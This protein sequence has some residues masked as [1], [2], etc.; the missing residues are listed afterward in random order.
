MAL[1]AALEELLKTLPVDVQAQQ[2]AILE[3]HPALGEGWLRQ[4]DYSQK[5]NEI[6]DRKKV[7]DE[8]DE[9]YKRNRPIYDQLRTDYQSSQ[10]R[11]TALEAEVQAKATELAAARAAG[12][13]GGGDPQAVAKAVMDSLQGKIPTQSELSKM[14]EDMTK[15][16]A[17]AAREAFFKNDVPS[18]LAFQTAMNDVQWRYRDEF[19][20]S[21]DRIEFAKFMKDNALADP[22]DAYDKYTAKAREERKLAEARA[23]GKAEGRKE[24]TAE[25]VPGSTGPQSPGHLQLRISEKKAGDPLFAQDIELGDTSAANAAAAELRA[26][27]KF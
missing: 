4:Q 16:Q 5:L 13:E 7:Y 8:H 23:E 12:G 2:R 17:D 14:I 15:K 26:E 3:K 20:K 24:A 10:E 19:G 18:V 11:I 21:M 1:N 25:F 27:G 6:S 9:W 22:I